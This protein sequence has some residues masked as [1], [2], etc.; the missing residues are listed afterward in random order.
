MFCRWRMDSNGPFK[1]T[2]KQLFSWRFRVFWELQRPS[3]YWKKAIWQRTCNRKSHRYLEKRLLWAALN[4]L[5]KYFKS[6][7]THLTFHFSPKRRQRAM[8]RLLWSFVFFKFQ[9]DQQRCGLGFSCSKWNRREWTSL[10]LP[11]K[12]QWAFATREVLQTIRMLLRWTKWNWTLSQRV[13]CISQW[14]WFSG[15]YTWNCAPRKNHD[16][17]FK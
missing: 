13:C 16:L 6:Y 7:I 17:L 15:N 9:L 14:S 11:R 12:L 4:Q 5:F 2:S 8:V 3:L 10:C 1:I